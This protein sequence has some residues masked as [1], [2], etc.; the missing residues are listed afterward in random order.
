MRQSIVLAGLVA[1]V[2]AS[3]APELMRRQNIDFSSVDAAPAPQ[4][5]GPP[6]TATSQN[7]DYNTA[8]VTASGAAAATAVASA[9]ATAPKRRSEIAKR[10]FCFWPFSCS[11]GYNSGSNSGSGSG[12]GGSSNPAPATSKAGTPTTTVP[13]AVATY[14]P[15]Q[16]CAIQG[17]GMFSCTDYFV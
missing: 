1:A 8:A 5:V 2:T 6:V 3:P 16:E 4:F 9:S 11:A 10:T 17:D 14:D 7:I 13:V 12:S 15:S